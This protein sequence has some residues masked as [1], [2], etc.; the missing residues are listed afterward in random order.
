M[1]KRPQYDQRDNRQR[2]LVSKLVS[3]DRIPATYN[4]EGNRK[5][6]QADMPLL[7][8]ISDTTAATISDIESMYQLLPDIE[9]ASQILISSILSPKDLSIPMLRFVCESESI[10]TAAASKLLAVLEEY[11]V[12]DYK[13]NASLSRLISEA[14]IK[15]GSVPRMIIPESSLDQ[16][17]N[18]KGP[19]T[20]ESIA[21]YRDH[22]TNG[23][24][25][26]NLGMLGDPSRVA[27]GSPSME[28]LFDDRT[29]VDYS[30]VY[31]MQ[32]ESAANGKPGKKLDLITVT[33]NPEVM[34]IPD[35]LDR[36]R[37]DRTKNVLSNRYM[38]LESVKK[39]R[40]SKKKE[41]TKEKLP[42]A[43]MSDRDIT[44]A[45]EGNREIKH[46]NILEIRT[47]HQVD[48]TMHGH[49][50]DV[51]LPSEAVIPA[52]VPGSPSDHI[53]YYV[54]LDEYGYPLNT[55][56][57]EDHYRQLQMSFKRNGSS[58]SS[59]SQVV[60]E[61]R[62]TYGTSAD[63]GSQ[64]ETIM[65][66]T[67]Q[68]ADIIEKNLLQRVRSGTGNMS[69]VL[70]RPTHLYQI[71]LARTAARKGTKL[72]YVP[73]ELMS[74]LAFYYNNN[75]VGRSILENTR[76]L[77]GIRVLLMF[78]NAVNHVRN[79]TP[80]TELG[81]TLDPNDTDPYGTISLIKNAFLK[82]R[83]DGFP[84]GA[85]RPDA[86]LNYLHRAGVDVVY[87]GHED[88][89]EM[90]IETSDANRS[91]PTVDDNIEE[92][93][94]E[95]HIMAFGISP[96][97]VD[98]SKKVDFATTIVNSS[99]LLSKRVMTYQVVFEEHQADFIRKYTNNSEIL[100]NRLLETVEEM[101]END[102][103]SMDSQD[104][105]EQFLADFTVVLPKPDSASL[106]AKMS[107][108]QEYT[109]AVKEAI[110]SFIS[111][112]MA[113]MDVDGEM[114]GSLRE[115][116]AAWTALLVR[117]Y[118]RDNDILPEIQKKLDKDEDGVPLFDFAKSHSAHM[119]SVLDTMRDYI[120]KGNLSKLKREA[121][122]A[123]EEKSME[124][125][126]EA[127][128]KRM[129]GDKM[130][131][132]VVESSDDD[133][134]GDDGEDPG[135]SDGDDAVDDDGADEGDDGTG[136][137]AGD[138]ADTDT[139]DAEG[140]DGADPGESDGDDDLDDTGSDP[141]EDDGDDDLDDTG[142]DPGEDDGDDDLGGD[143]EPEEK[144]EKPE[145]APKEEKSK[146]EPKVKEEKPEP[147]EKDDEPEEEEVE[148]EE[149][150]DKEE[151]PE[152][153]EEED[154]EEEPEEDDKEEEKDDKPSK[155]E[156]K[157]DKE[158]EPEED[159]AIEDDEDKEDGD[160]KDDV[161]TKIDPENEIDDED[162]DK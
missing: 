38:T 43:E 121:V 132:E 160:K 89:P 100:L 37:K 40:E 25:V 63:S 118:M 110:E 53:G 67:D 75:G 138:D 85:G 47:K 49:P 55:S 45:L 5:L 46:K 74:Y 97:T 15:K 125:K 131:E 150:E 64:V 84:L 152:E 42:F 30:P 112:D 101:D 156:K 72:L 146:P 126:V 35:L 71:M 78:S 34:R 140:D 17:I 141:G 122:V 59:L 109:G 56:M 102:T 157:E 2:A 36:L 24:K 19:V 116:R 33:D 80:R 153:K 145:P 11:F 9:L 127:Y 27:D 48:R 139:D 52:Y 22:A 79:A 7:D 147:E 136:D 154:T 82:S 134:A 95:R 135:E 39:K 3:S 108:L 93:Y 148:E 128:I 51:E 58:E 142:S 1:N 161:I 23:F 12:K 99:L 98:A 106:N 4:R 28:S 41:D 31:S 65:A 6:S 32:L 143:D 83:S 20:L 44:R 159:D 105:V 77:G 130:A 96:E 88:L 124:E 120:T 50:M 73:A 123:A 92:D 10:S 151:E 155:P 113:I 162:K 57:I 29:N 149:P 129:Y 137:D 87:N 115:Y 133:D 21:A 14:L 70:A 69:A 119:D 62:G 18:N 81:I 68:F 117:E 76:V 107:A 13:I 8:Q 16:I 114:A 54:P 103:Q 90:K 104:I 94:R 26:N 111:D 91:R 60:R 158:E 86:A 66:A 144:E 61:L